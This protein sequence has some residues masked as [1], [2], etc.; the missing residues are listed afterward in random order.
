MKYINTQNIK[1]FAKKYGKQIHGKDLQV[2][3]EFITQVHELVEAV[4]KSNVV[5][6]DNLAGTL[7]S[8]DW[9]NNCIAD[10]NSK[11]Q[12]IIDEV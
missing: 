12:E 7:R 9:G 6:Q 11:M 3:L 10:A 2:S 5:Q 1:L 8:T 4:V